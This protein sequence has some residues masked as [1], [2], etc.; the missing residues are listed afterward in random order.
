MNI[1]ESLHLK[2][3]ARNTLDKP[4]AQYV[5][6]PYERKDFLYW[7]KSIKFPDGY[8]A[9][10]SHK[11]NV[12]EGS[13][14]G[15]KSHDCHVLMQRVLPVGIRKYLKKHIYGPIVEFSSFFQQICAK[16]LTVTDLDK[17][18]ED[19]VLILCKLEK[20]FPSAFFVPMVHLAV[21]LPCEAKLA[22][23]VGYRWMYPVER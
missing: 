4:L 9:N 3:N 22:G 21:H 6:K 10:I 16:T 23:L 5:F 11:V 18:E 19:I 17:L 12:D 2:L 8:A 7:L 14:F 20:N 1:R 13:I 15:L